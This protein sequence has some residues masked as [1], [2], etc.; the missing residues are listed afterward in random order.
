MK[1]TLPN[2]PSVAFLKQIFIHHLNRIYNGK[3]FL[4]IKLNGLISLA[5]FKEL[6]LAMEE[7]GSDVRK[8]ILR[9]EEIY[10]LTNETPSN[11]IQNPIKSIVADEFFIVGEQT[12]PILNDL[13]IMLYVQVL[14]Y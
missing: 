1:P 3:N 9:M 6:Q 10:K 2:Q 11:D 7:F 12:A 4:N 14:A 5:S 13:D 8:Q